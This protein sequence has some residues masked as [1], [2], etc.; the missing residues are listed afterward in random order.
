LAKVVYNSCY[1]GFNLSEKAMVRYRELGGTETYDDDIS[2]TDPRLIQV[3]EEL[4]REAS[5]SCGLLKIAEVPSG[6]TYRIDEYDGF[7][8]VMTVDDYD[9]EVAP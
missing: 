9:W 4:G 1:G 2:R 5:G 7:E 3:V 8:S 6:A